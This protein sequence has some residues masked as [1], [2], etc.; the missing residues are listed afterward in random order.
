MI[1][2]LITL[3]PST[4]FCKFNLALRISWFYLTASNY[5]DSSLIMRLLSV[6]SSTNVLILKSVFFKPSV[7]FD[8]NS[9][10]CMN[11]NSVRV[12]IHYMIMCFLGRNS[13]ILAARSWFLYITKWRSSAWNNGS[14]VVALIWKCCIRRSEALYIGMNNEDE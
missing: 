10:V 7:M 4:A 12:S 2:S 13:F 8:L 3:P 11:N 14:K 6:S 9:D 5:P 1:V